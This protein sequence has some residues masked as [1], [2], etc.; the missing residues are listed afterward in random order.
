ME[1]R[2]TTVYI[3]GIYMN[4]LCQHCADCEFHHYE[5][6][7]KKGNKVEFDYSY[8]TVCL[9]QATQHLERRRENLQRKR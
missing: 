4:T 9:Q 2:A 5:R 7:N 1:R 3:G 8:V 6:Y